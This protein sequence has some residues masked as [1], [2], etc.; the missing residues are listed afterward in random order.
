MLFPLLDIHLHQQF[1]FTES[2]SAIMVVYIFTLIAIFVIVIACINFINLST[3]KA[4]ARG[5][6]IGI[7]KVAG[8]GQTSTIVQFMLE[9]LMLVAAAM[10]FAIILLDCSWH[11]Q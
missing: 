1:G 9:S 2:K 10:V 4:A 8:A 5:K 11:F 7:K 6:E 3:A